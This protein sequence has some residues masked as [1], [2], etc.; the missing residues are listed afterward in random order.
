MSKSA[1]RNS[2]SFSADVPVTPIVAAIPHKDNETN[3]AWL[4]QHADGRVFL[5]LSD[6]IMPY[7]HAADQ[8]ALPAFGRAWTHDPTLFKHLPKPEA[9]KLVDELPEGITADITPRDRQRLR[10]IIDKHWRAYFAEKPTN[11]Q[12]DQLIDALGPRVAAQV[13][14][15]QVD[16]GTIQ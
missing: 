12:K 11:R 2:A 1:L 3:G 14:K 8:D 7:A 13:V 6:T 9:P 4:C 16:R 5:T 15:K 10:A